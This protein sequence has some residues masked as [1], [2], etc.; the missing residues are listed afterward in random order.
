MASTLAVEAIFLYGFR[1]MESILLL[2]ER[3]MS[4][5]LIAFV[6]AALVCGERDLVRIRLYRSHHRD[7]IR[8]DCG[9]FLW[10]SD[11]ARGR[12]IDS[13]NVPA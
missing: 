4:T 9:Q 2:T 12:E 3:P 10:H 13:A 5:F 8:H 11:D 1:R 6:L 7:R